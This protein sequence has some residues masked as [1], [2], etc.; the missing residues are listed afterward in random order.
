MHLTMEIEFL[1]THKRI[2]F[3]LKNFHQTHSQKATFYVRRRRKACLTFSRLK[4]KGL[5]CGNMRP[6]LKLEN[7]VRS[8]KR[9]HA[10]VR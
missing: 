1:Q 2:K 10:K 5:H 6:K 9:D 4:S 8:F 7:E 3:E